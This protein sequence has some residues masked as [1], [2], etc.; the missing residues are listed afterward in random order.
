MKIVVIGANG[1]AG[2]LIVKEA[3]LRGHE[4][5]AVVRSENISE[6]SE[7]IKKDLFDLTKEDLKDFDVVVSAFGAFTPETLPLHSK[8]IE[9]FADLLENSEVRFL[10]VGGAGSLYIDNTHTV[11]LLDT[12]EFPEE[13]KPLATAQADELTLL[14]TKENLNW[15]F[16]SPAANFIENGEKTGN[17]VIAG[18]VF[19]TND[20]GESFVSYADYASAMVDVIDSGDYIKERISI[21]TK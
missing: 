8:S 2:R 3:K 4:V 7:V 5:A 9:H 13:F 21:Y 14:R 20:N 19:T 12:P 11:K 18:E 1:K 10:V 6:A 16:V 15:T 17:Y